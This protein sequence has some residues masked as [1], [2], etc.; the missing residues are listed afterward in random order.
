[1]LHG[2]PQSQWSRGGCCCVQVSTVVAVAVKEQRDDAKY[3]ESIAIWIALFAVVFVSESQAP[4]ARAHEALQRLCMPQ[5]HDPSGQQPPG[6]Q[7]RDLY[8][9]H[10]RFQPCTIVCHDRQP[11]LSV[12]E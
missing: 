8:D 11:S 4:H 2:G 7:R 10:G 6:A 5:T 9:R 12:C 1:M 3:I